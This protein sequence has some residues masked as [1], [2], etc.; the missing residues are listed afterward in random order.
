MKEYQEGKHTVKIYDNGDKHWLIN[1]NLHRED[2]PA[3]E[4]HDGTKLWY[5]NDKL[6]RE[7]GPAAEYANG[8]KVWAL[9]NKIYNNINSV[10]EL[11]IASIIE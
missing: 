10:D 6:H 11:I 5:F 3:C 7:D 8:I 1:D 9:N 4:F 2:G